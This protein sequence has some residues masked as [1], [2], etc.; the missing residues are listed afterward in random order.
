MFRYFGLAYR[1]AALQGL[2]LIACVAVVTSPGLA[3]GM[4]HGEAQW[5]PAAVQ[6]FFKHLDNLDISAGP[7]NYPKREM[8]AKVNAEFAKRVD[9]L[10]AVFRAAGGKNVGIVPKTGALRDLS[11]QIKIWKHCRRPPPGGTQAS[12][13][14][15]WVPDVYDDKGQPTTDPPPPG[16]KAHFQVSASCPLAADK[17]HG[18]WTRVIEGSWHNVGLAVDFGQFTAAEK[19]TGTLQFLNEAAWGKVWTAMRDLGML[20]GEYFKDPDHPH[21]EWHPGLFKAEEAGALGAAATNLKSGYAWQFPSTV[22]SWNPD[23]QNPANG[24]LKVIDFGSDGNWITVKD[25]RTITTGDNGEWSGTWVTYNPAVKVFPTYISTWNWQNWD[26]GYQAVTTVEERS[27][28]RTRASSPYVNTP[29]TLVHE[30]WTDEKGSL[31]YYPS[32]DIVDRQNEADVAINTAKHYGTPSQAYKNV[33]KTWKILSANSYYDV[34]FGANWKGSGYPST[35]KAHAVTHGF[36]KDGSDYS[37]SD[38]ETTRQG[39]Q[40]GAAGTGY[41]LGLGWSRETGDVGQFIGPSGT[42][43]YTLKATRQMAGKTQAYWPVMS[44][45][46][47]AGAKDQ[48]APPSWPF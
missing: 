19:Y 33:F 36:E 7:G 26:A 23:P 3:N 25:S 34:S 9:V 39:V 29:N 35:F 30:S 41:S 18:L 1:R 42:G 14:A 11:D 8:L 43:P 44:S 38:T 40:L 16:V 20:S 31:E 32:F 5:D 22:Y 45:K 10:M 21:V 48:T 4:L 46:L 15:T 24:Q 27:Y 12:A 47:P 6:L 2:V 17:S 28:G 37:P 13:P